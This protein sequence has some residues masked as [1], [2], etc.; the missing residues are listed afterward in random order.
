MAGG[1]AGLLLHA[2]HRGITDL[3]S[4]YNMGMDPLPL[5]PRPKLTKAFH[6]ACAIILAEIESGEDEKRVS[7]SQRHKDFIPG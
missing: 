1:E 5:P 2:F 3:Y 4:F 6:Y 7:P